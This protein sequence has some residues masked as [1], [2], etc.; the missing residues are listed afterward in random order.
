MIF[1]KARLGI[2]IQQVHESCMRYV[3]QNAPEDIHDVMKGSDPLKKT[4]Y[5]RSKVEAHY[6]HILTIPFERPT[7]ATQ[8][9]RTSELLLAAELQRIYSFLFWNK[10]KP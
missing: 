7:A 4:A 8:A 1:E 5:I 10:T 6:Q 9:G 3:K 2:C